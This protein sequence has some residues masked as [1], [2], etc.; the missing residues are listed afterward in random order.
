MAILAELFRIVLIALLFT[1]LLG[2]GSP[3]GAESFD[4]TNLVSDDPTNHPAQITDPSLQNAWG[5]S[6]TPNGSPFWVSSNAG[7]VANLYSVNS[8]NVTT[9]VLLGGPPGN[10]TIPSAPGSPMGTLGTPTGQAFNPANGSGAFNGDTFLFVSE[11]GTISGWRNALGTTA[12]VLQTGSPN[13]VYKGTAL[14][15]T[16][17]HAYLLSANFKTGNIDVLKGDQGAPALA[18]KFTDPNLPSGFAPFNIQVLGGIVYIAYA[19]QD[20]TGHDDDPGKGNG[21]VSAF[22]MDG[23]FLSRIGTQGTLNSPWGL[24]IAPAS[25]GQFAGNLLVGNFGDGT[26][27][28]FSPNPAA[29]GFLG[30]LAGANGTPLGIDGLWALIPGNG[31]NSGNSQ[32]IYFSAGPD[33]ETRGLFGVISAVPE[34]P[35]VLLLLSGIATE[36]LVL[37]RQRS[38]A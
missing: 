31:G 34:P 23:S 19:K 30:Q 38:G 5:V 21:F 13:D 14:V 6:Y 32:S 36:W 24:A 18:G 8:A 20:A 7:G 33:G 26:I 22:R 12:E 11:D 15:M 35:T 27:N 10:V 28:A 1:F 2:P 29:P 4:V 17:G 16:G 37:R 9:K 25:F 3:A